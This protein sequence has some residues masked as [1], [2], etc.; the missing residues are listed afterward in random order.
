[1][2]SAERLPNSSSLIGL[3]KGFENERDRKITS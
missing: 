3:D 1:M 2:K